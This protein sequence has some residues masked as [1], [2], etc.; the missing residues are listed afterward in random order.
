M[1]RAHLWRYRWPL[2]LAALLTVVE[3]AVDLARPWP[4]LLAIDHAI[5]RQPL[6]QPWASWLAPVSSPTGLAATAALAVLFLALA[7]A[8]VRYLDVYLADACAERVG[9]DIRDS[10]HAHLLRLS[11]RFHHRQ[12][13]GDLASRLTDDVSRV[14]AG[15]VAWFSSV[16]PEVLTLAG[17]AVVLVLIDR[18]LALA[19]LSVIPPLALV[20]ALRR[21]RLRAAQLTYRER[22]G[23]LAAGVTETMRNVSLVQAFGLERETQERFRDSNR[24]TAAAGLRVVDLNAQ[25]QP[26]A[27]VILAAGSALVLWVGVTRVLDGSITVGMLV[28]VVTYVAS[29]YGPIRSL[30]Q[31]SGVLGKAAASRERL[32][33]ILSS[34]QLLPVLAGA[35]AMPWPTSEIAVRSVSFAYAGRRPALVDIHLRIPAGGTFCVVGPTGAGKSTLLS[36][37]VRLYDPDEGAIAV[38]GRDLRTFDLLS[39]RRRMALVPQDPAIFDGTLRAN[40]VIGRP[41]AP[42]SAVARAASLA[43]LDAFAASL[44]AGYDTPVGEGGLLLSGGQRR[45]LAIARALVREAPVLLLDEPTSGLDVESEVQVMNAIR[46]AGESA[47]VVVVTHRLALAA[48]ADQVA[49]LRGGRIAEQGTPAE[50]LAAGGHFARLWNLHAPAARSRETA[51]VLAALAAGDHP[52]NVRRKEVIQGVSDQGAVRRW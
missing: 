22:E 41:D 47:T 8:V 44:P 16:A 36:L 14:Q 52:D 15:V 28:V 23:D 35:P 2:A 5:G 50:L 25:Y 4:L 17:M 46:V 29:I 26:T 7:V 31:L 39:V 9:A 21:K 13:T 48:L 24:A 19:A 20:A 1:G 43:Q 45:C 30:A 10:L 33:E 49:V 18:V 37:L 6:D 32:S 27:N 40:I 11:L 51:P 3:T 38:D 12:R 42:D 34:D